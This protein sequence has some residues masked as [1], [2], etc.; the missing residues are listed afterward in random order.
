M[1]NLLK[2]LRIEYSTLVMLEGVTD[3]PK[4]TSLRFHEKMLH[5]FLEGQNND[6]FISNQERERLQSKTNMQL[7]LRELLLEHSKSAVFVCMSLPMPRQDTV[8]APLYMSWLEILTK[9]MPPML[10]VRGN[11]S[12][13]VTYYS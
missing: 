13:V 4:E 11:Q 6:C 9:D 8:S 2:K 12:S 3:P 5:G 1:A 7:R 10:L